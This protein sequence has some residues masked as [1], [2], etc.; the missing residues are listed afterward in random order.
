MPFYAVGVSKTETTVGC[1]YIEADS[2]KAAAK[3][4]KKMDTPYELFGNLDHS[5]NEIQNV[6][7]SVNFHTVEKCDEESV[8][9]DRLLS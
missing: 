5:F 7:Y 1:F 9:S 3:I 8:D 4:A 6:E 2:L